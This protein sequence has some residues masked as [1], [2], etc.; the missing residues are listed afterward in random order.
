A[1]GLDAD[2]AL[3]IDAGREIRFD[4]APDFHGTPG[5]LDVRLAD[6]DSIDAITE[7][8]GAGDLKDLSSEGGTGETGRWS[9]DTVTIQTSVDPVNDRPESDDAQLAPIDEGNLA[10][11][12]ETIGN[13]FGGVFDD[14]TDDQSAIP[15]GGNSSTALGGIAIVGNDATAAQGTWQYSSDGGAN[16]N[17]ISTSVSDSDAVTLAND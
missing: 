16:W 13:L 4:P 17:D 7:S 3:V 1:T 15:G 12:G 10:P 6:G 2:N 5:T 9:A 14:A 8:T 11:S